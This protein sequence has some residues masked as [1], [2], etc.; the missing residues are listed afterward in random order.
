MAHPSPA[1][2]LHCS[3][4]TLYHQHYTEE[5]QGDCFDPCLLEYMVRSRWQTSGYAGKGAQAS[6]VIELRAL[7]HRR[8]AEV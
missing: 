1:S 4:S 8:Y 7:M 3:H 5:A 2:P 6:Q